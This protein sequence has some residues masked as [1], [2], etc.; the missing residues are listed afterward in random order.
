MD[1]KITQPDEF[2][3]SWVE[4]RATGQRIGRVTKRTERTP[5]MTN[6]H[7]YHYRIG[8]TERTV[9]DAYLGVMGGRDRIGTYTRRSDAVWYLVREAQA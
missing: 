2:G 7:G 4:D 8:V 3:S 5:V 9:W 1:T 6:D